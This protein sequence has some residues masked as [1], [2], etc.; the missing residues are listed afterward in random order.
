M[1]TARNAK[2][3]DIIAYN[4]DASRLIGIQVKSLSQRA[5]VPLGRS[6]KEMGDFWIIVNKLASDEPSAYIM[7]PAEVG[8]LAHR[9]E[10]DGRVSFWL[11]TSKYETEKFC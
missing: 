1:P 7:K 4:H 11:Q 10:K 5:P 3:V 8:K 9:G 6:V 2:G